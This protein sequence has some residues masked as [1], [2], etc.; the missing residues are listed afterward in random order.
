VGSGSFWL[1]RLILP[2]GLLT[3]QALPLGAWLQLGAAWT[4]HDA[5]QTLLPTWALL[6]LLVEAFWL[7][8]W[9]TQQPLLKT[10]TPFLIGIGGLVTFLLTCYLRFYTSSG[11]F[12]QVNWLGALLQD[13]QAGGNRL[14][15]PIGLSILVVLLWWRGLRLGR[16]VIESEQVGW[17]FKGGFAALVL[18]LALIGTV[19]PAA[20]SAVG[21]QLG[22]ELPLFLFVGLATISLARLT[23]IRRERRAQG[24]TQADPTRSW[25][26]VMLVLSGALVVL[27]LGIEQ[28]FSYQIWLSVVRPA[29]DGISTALG[30][31]SVG[32]AFV[33]YW[34]FHP[35]GQL[36]GTF[37][38]KNNQTT[39]S[40]PP[41]PGPLKPPHGT[42]KLVLP[43]D[44]LAAGRWVLIGIG[45]AV[46]LL[47]LVRAFR[48]LAS[49][50]R[51]EEVDEERE[52]LEAGSILGMQLRSLLASLAARFQRKQ[53]TASG[54]QDET[55]NTVR[56]LY[57]RMLRQAAMHGVERQITETPQEF[58]QRLSLA[59]ASPPA[60]LPASP[61]EHAPSA[62]GIVPSSL[63]SVSDSEL[64]E[65]TE[66]YE[67][68]RYGDQELSA[69]QVSTLSSGVDRLTQRIAQRQSVP[70]GHDG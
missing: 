58:A 61:E 6:L 68:V 59:L 19:D 7:A 36:V 26:V 37:F 31:L 15:A 67:Q 49:W 9:R 29:W 63:P 55:G 62:A 16:R 48:F 18:A 42:N 51:D 25:I 10:W 44:W 24:T 1:E 43:A 65:L 11:P 56:I 23:E 46:L 17:N 38:Q 2:L 13:I 27:T 14:V 41:L 70:P 53:T 4:A 21:V 32:I 66:A 52:S 8:R 35:L 69:T 60:R 64:V 50:G 39:S 3:L 34:I 5:N 28:V 12:W 20:Q 54:E 45:V 33:L 30:W 40:S 47:I 57:R 22:L